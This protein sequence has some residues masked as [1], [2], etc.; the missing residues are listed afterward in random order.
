[1]ARNPGQLGAL[2]SAGTATIERAPAQVAVAVS[3]LELTREI[4]GES[5]LAV[6]DR[7]T[8]ELVPAPTVAAE[9][10]APGSPA[11]AAAAVSHD[12][13]SH[14]AVTW[15]TLISSPKEAATNSARRQSPTRTVDG[16]ISR[17]VAAA[18]AA[19]CNEDLD[20]TSQAD[21]LEVILRTYLDAVG[22]TI[23]D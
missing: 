7:A 8:P 1:M 3:D 14:R 11:A 6:D 9:R 19:H 20:N 17:P 21:L 13:R 16:R 22:K 2:I 18:F 4:A 12:R 15:K 10:P 23:R 5:P